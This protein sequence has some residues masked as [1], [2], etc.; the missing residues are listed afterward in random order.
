MM[1]VKKR[2]RKTFGENGGEVDSFIF[3]TYATHH[4]VRTRDVHIGG[5]RN[6]RHARCP[7]N[8]KAN[9]SFFR[10]KVLFVH[11]DGSRSERFVLDD[12]Y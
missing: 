5:S 12:R 2:N 6:S 9:K 8:E 7:S 4:R 3:A 1:C 11:R 10:D